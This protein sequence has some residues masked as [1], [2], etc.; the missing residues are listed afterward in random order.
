MKTHYL[1]L[2]TLAFPLL[3]SAQLLA[4]HQP[5]SQQHL[6]ERYPTS[7]A[8]DYR[9]AGTPFWSEDFSGGFPAGW[10]TD[11]PTGLCPWRYSLD[12][13]YGWFNGSNGS[14][15]GD[16]IA[17]T[18]AANG[19]LIA[20]NDSAN[21]ANFGQPSGTTYQYIDTYF[22]TNAIDLSSH[23]FVKLEF[24][25][26][27]RFNNEVDMEVMVST[28]SASWTTFLVQGDAINNQ[29]SE[30]AETIGINISN[31]AGGQPTVYLR[32]GWSA[33]VYYWMID[34]IR[35][36]EAPAYDVRVDNFYTSEWIFATATD[37]STLEYSM[38]PISQARQLDMKA[39]V[40]NEGVAVQN[41]VQL[42]T[43]VTDAGGMNVYSGT[44]NQIT[45]QPG[46]TDSLYTTGF[47]P[48]SITGRY[49]VNYMVTSDSLDAVPSDNSGH[50]W[51]E[52][53]D[54]IFARDTN[55]LDDNYSNQG[56]AYQLGNW[57]NIQNQNEVLYGIDVAIDDAT[58]IQTLIY[59]EV[60]D[61]DRL[62]V[63][64]TV[65]YEVQAS[66]LNGPGG[67]K[68]VTLIMN[69]PLN[70]TQGEDY[71]VTVGYFGGMDELFIGTSG[72]SLPQ[73]SLIYD[74]PDATW[75]YVTQTPMVRMNLDP[76]VS[77]QPSAEMSGLALEQNYP[78]P[79][80]DI[81]TIRY[82]LDKPIN[83]SIEVRDVHGK[84]VHNEQL[85]RQSTGVHLYE[86]QTDRLEA[87]VYTYTL[88]GDAVRLTKRMT[89]LGK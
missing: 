65:Q 61:G 67:N 19:F 25:Q 5:E 70:L 85:G 31:I 47:T 59:G 3:G 43:E 69:P 40:T 46:S 27:F 55:A 23:P 34:D 29:A 83:L 21:H 18:T 58:D 32:F 41:N 89:V 56:N 77:I 36:V 71:L 73:T 57:F 88:Q 62:P 35:I 60:F 30:N 2:F 22:A 15:S 52:V 82:R 26:Y 1:F 38:Y 78:N 48:P 50:T 20:D 12:G 64:E 16:T 14:M 51:L 68:F 72:V 80:T 75:F 10:A 63:G 44:S 49:D 54:H 76:T 24:E 79:A 4:P 45:M 11:N 87:G 39:R 66:D 84:L 17:S 86:L 6:I 42:Q 74:D 81:T 7:S 13:S 53:T 37:Y 28:D 9:S 8:P 33:R